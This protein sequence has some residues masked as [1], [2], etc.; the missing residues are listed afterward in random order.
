MDLLIFAPLS[1]DGD[2]L[3]VIACEKIQTGLAEFD[4]ELV[5]SE[6]NIGHGADWTVLLVTLGGIFLLGEKVQKNLDAWIAVAQRA[7]KL[8]EWVKDKCGLVRVDE[9]AAIALAINDLILGKEAISSLQL[10][11]LQTIPFTPVPWN[12]RNRLDGRP[13]ALYLFG[14]RVNNDE[15]F[16]YGVKS[17]G[18]IEFKHR[19]PVFWGEF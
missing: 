11:F 18:V 13:D 16:V 14:L 19:Y 4:S 15:V 9:S 7:V 17:K 6:R 10:E 8:M 3:D 5:V 12:P 2:S 1:T